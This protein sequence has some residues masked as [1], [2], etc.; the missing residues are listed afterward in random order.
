VF[1]ED[2]FFAF[3]NK[4]YDLENGVLSIQD[5]TIIYPTPADTITHNYPAERVVE[6]KNSLILS[7]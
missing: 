7:F 6:L 2:P 1:N 4:V 5:T 3:N